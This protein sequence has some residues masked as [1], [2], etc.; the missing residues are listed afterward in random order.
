M[1]YPHVSLVTMFCFS[2][3]SEQ[4]S[5]FTLNNLHSPHHPSSPPQHYQTHLLSGSLYG[6]WDNREQRFINS[7]KTEAPLSAR[8]KSYEKTLLCGTF[9][10]DRNYTTGLEWKKIP[11]MCDKVAKDSLFCTTEK[12]HQLI[13]MVLFSDNQ[14]NGLQLL[15]MNCLGRDENL[16]GIIATAS[17]TLKRIKAMGGRYLNLTQVIKDISP[18]LTAQHDV[19]MK[20][21][22]ILDWLWKLSTWKTVS[23]SVKFICIIVGST[24]QKISSG[25]G[26]Y[27]WEKATFYFLFAGL[28]LRL[29]SLLFNLQLIFS[30]NQSDIWSIQSQKIMKMHIRIAEKSSWYIENVRFYRLTVQNLKILICLIW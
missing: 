29:F 8:K 30:I 28:L 9:Q 25:G 14:T 17:F 2:V 27:S 16:Q 24:G 21:Q 18:T 4:D 6:C 19:W 7:T 13:T 15:L 23:A 3:N 26:A 20:M 12:L 1:H 11:N 22:T 5:S 10:G